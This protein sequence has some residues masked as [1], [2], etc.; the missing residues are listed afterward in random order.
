MF[1]GQIAIMDKM[2]E[3]HLI[4]AALEAVR[5]LGL[6]GTVLAEDVDTATGRAD[7]MMRLKFGG[8]TVDYVVEAKR[9]L[10]A[11][12]LG[13]ALNQLARFQGNKILITDHITPPM[14]DELRKRGVEFID[15]AGNAYLNQPPLL[16]WIKGQRPTEQLW[17][18]EQV[19]RA[20][21]TTG[22]QVLF[23]LLCKP[24]AVNLPYREIAALAGVAHGTVGWVMPELPKLGFMIE[25][26]KRRRLVDGER[27]LKQWVDAYIRK[28]R[29]KLVLGRYAADALDWALNIDAE[30]Y[31]LLLGGEPAAYRMTKHLRPGTA[32][33][34]GEKVDPKF[35]MD[36]R[37]RPDPN[38]NVELLKRFW[39]FEETTTGMVPPILIYADL[40]ATGD[41]RC[42]ETAGLIYDAI[43]DRLK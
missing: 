37:L 2:T 32:T 22:L 25:I 19:G 41:A 42:L 23:T 18:K 27:L 28:L 43:A 17:P 13:H 10:R 6:H 15:T 39:K 29:P 31:G 21:Q 38:G 5:P 40:L 11:G 35:L 20:F 26:N 30:K 3:K 14:A 9:N 33:F 24:E 4:T 36:Q 12:I 16:V 1:C 34:Y 7:A 8:I